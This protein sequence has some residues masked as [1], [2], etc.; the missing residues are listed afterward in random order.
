LVINPISNSAP[1]LLPDLTNR[2]RKLKAFHLSGKHPNGAFDLTVVNRKLT[3]GIGQ[4]GKRQ[5]LSFF[6]KGVFLISGFQF[7]GFSRRS[8]LG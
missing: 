1:E 7:A 4:Q 6:V 8:R 2:H 5:G 3:V